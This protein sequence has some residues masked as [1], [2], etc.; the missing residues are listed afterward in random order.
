MPSPHVD[1]PRLILWAAVCLALCVCG[2][3]PVGENSVST[4]LV[5][6]VVVEV[7]GTTVDAVTGVPIAGLTIHIRRSALAG[8]AGAPEPA[9]V[10]A[11]AGGETVTTDVDG[12]FHLA[13]VALDVEKFAYVLEVSD[14]RE[15]AEAER[16]RPHEAG[17]VYAFQDGK[18]EFG[19][20]G[21]VRA[22]LAD[23]TTV[24]GT[25]KEA[26]Y[27][28]RAIEGAVVTLALRE[29]GE[30]PFSVRTG[31]DGRF[32][33]P[34]VPTRD[35]ELAIVAT[36]ARLDG[37]PQAFAGLDQT[38]SIRSEDEDLDE[39]LDDIAVDLGTFYLVPAAPSED[40]RILLS[41]DARTDDENDY[42]FDLDA[43][44]LLPGPDCDINHLSGAEVRLENSAIPLSP[45]SGF[46]AS[47]CYWPAFLNGEAGDADRVTVDY[48][49][50]FDVVPREANGDAPAPACA[51]TFSA[52]ELASLDP[53]VAPDVVSALLSGKS[54]AVASLDSDSEDGSSPEVVT[55]K[56]DL[57]LK[58]F[59][60]H[61]GYAYEYTLDEA[62][63]T[64]LH[65]PVGVAVY[66][67]R[68][69]LNEGDAPTNINES[70]ATV[71]V[72]EGNTRIARRRITELNL[73]ESVQDWT[74]FLIEVGFKR[75]NPLS[76]ADVYFRLMPFEGMDWQT[77][78]NA[79]AW[80]D[81]RAAAALE[82]RNGAPGSAPLESAYT[83]VDANGQL[84]VAGSTGAGDPGG[85]SYGTWRLES[86]TTGRSRFVRERSESVPTLALS[87][88][89]TSVYAARGQVMSVLDAA[90]RADG[91][92]SGSICGG[93]ISRVYAATSSSTVQ[94]VCTEAGLARF[95]AARLRCRTEGRPLGRVRA[96]GACTGFVCAASDQSCVPFEWRCDFASDCPNGEDEA[97]C[98]DGRPLA[99]EAGQFRCG[100]GLCLPAAWQCDG[101]IDC[102]ARDDELGCP[103]GGVCD[104]FVCG[105]RCLSFHAFC[106]GYVD[107]PGAVDEVACATGCDGVLCD[108]ETFCAERSVL[109]DGRSDCHDDRDESL[110]TGRPCTGVLCGDGRCV[111]GPDICDGLQDCPGGEDELSC[112]G[113]RCPGLRCADGTCLDR[114]VAC[115][116]RADCA[117]GDD[118]QRCDGPRCDGFE[119]L[120]G[121][122][123]ALSYTCDGV[124]DCPDGEDE[125]P[126]DSG[127]CETLFCDGRCI[128]AATVCNGREDC[129]DGAD[130]RGCPLADRPPPRPGAAPRPLDDPPAQTAL[131]APT[132][133]VAD[134][135]AFSFSPDLPNALVA[136][137]RTD[138]LW[139]RGLETSMDE[140]TQSSPND[141]EGVLSGPGISATALADFQFSL[142]VGASGGL[143]VFDGLSVDEP[144]KVRPLPVCEDRAADGAFDDADC[145]PPGTDIRALLAFEDRLFIGT[146]DGLYA[147]QGATAALANDWVVGRF[148]HFPPHVPVNGLTVSGG[149]LVVLTEGAGVFFVQVGAS[150]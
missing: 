15:V 112:E 9:A 56:K 107:C 80:E 125:L 45:Q 97:D 106:D 140:W 144:Y 138:G 62:G 102:P 90:P 150:R 79:F 94:F 137:S 31:A 93:E 75:A 10:G 99:C 135:V 111:A 129:S 116:G 48:R 47:T 78:P 23:R 131:A 70:G 92:Y 142:F 29:T 100:N 85:P 27:S 36:S 77:A 42:Y 19:A 126:C 118:E 22:I 82:G 91:G 16:F 30:V 7:D 8:D 59:P 54:C 26:R 141:L 132:G 95:D 149:R 55:L 84:F 146:A 57:F 113:G 39:A 14:A 83:A 109:C 53:P 117:G 68:N 72:F 121:A 33:I 74:V 6:P 41:W 133:P 136:A 18:V 127:R 110:C 67:V 50:H 60:K 21:V 71:E 143:Y 96:D 46:G 12:G 2:C 81:L 124:G 64:V 24:I 1:G 28:G 34:E 128:P 37:K 44:L 105:G 147:L 52:A 101:E 76:A 32:V 108:D 88:D 17:P 103:T 3:V 61:L 20:I 122:C 63:N 49:S 66:T 5:R 58:R 115:D 119:C 13:G 130:E 11:D 139:Y 87:F 38:V 25:L 145:L 89:G 104:G 123:I 65:Y 4:R 73:P 43:Q 40:L 51:Q 114:D 98:A 120:N 148:R 69:F 134:V 35:Y 86:D